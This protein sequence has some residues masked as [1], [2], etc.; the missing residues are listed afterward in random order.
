MGHLRRTA[1]LVAAFGFVAC[2][3]PIDPVSTDAA[4]LSLSELSTTAGGVVAATAGHGTYLLSGVL[5]IDFNWNVFMGADGRATGTFH[6]SLLLDDLLIS[7]DGKLTCLAVDPENHRAWVGGVVTQNDSEHPDFLTDI[8]EP[9]DDVW[10]RVLDEPGND[11]STFLGFEGAADIITSEE[12]CE[13]RIWPDNND[14]T[15]PVIEGSIAVRP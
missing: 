9:G 3:A 13:A 11:R 1:S 10:F 8:T 5:E 15:H 7:F 14:R 4:D 12:Y 6:Q 2:Q